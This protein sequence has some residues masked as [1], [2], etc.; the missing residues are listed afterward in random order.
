MP[1][2]FVDRWQ[3]QGKGVSDQRQQQQSYHCVSV[4]WTTHW[5]QDALQGIYVLP[6]HFFRGVRMIHV[7]A[8]SHFLHCL[9]GM[10]LFSN[11]G[12]S[13]LVWSHIMRWWTVFWIT[14]KM[15]LKQNVLF[16]FHF[17]SKVNLRVFSFSFKRNH[18]YTVI[19]MRAYYLFSFMWH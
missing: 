1:V 15:P 19:W 14:L 7:K 10:C 8:P 9:L 6:V 18:C 3:R 12:L 4:V 11:C 2:F 17:E 16:F 5:G 13:V